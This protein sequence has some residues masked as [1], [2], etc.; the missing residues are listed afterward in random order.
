[1]KNL[2]HIILPK[3]NGLMTNYE[4]TITSGIFQGGNAQ[5]L[6]HD[7]NLDGDE[8]LYLGDHIFGDVV[9]IKKSCNWRNHY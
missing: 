1:M 5:K 3:Q 9:S 8:I 4:G 7:L 6:Q 2:E